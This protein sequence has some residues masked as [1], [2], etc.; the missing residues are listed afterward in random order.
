MVLTFVLI[1]VWM[2]WFGYWIVSGRVANQPTTSTD[3][4]FAYL[5]P[6]LICD[7]LLI[8]PV[9]PVYSMPITGLVLT[10]AGLV[11]ASWARYRL[12]KNWSGH[13]TIQ[14]DHQLIT[15][16]PYRWCR[17]PI[18]LGVLAGFVGT[19]LYIGAATSLAA[20]LFAIYAFGLKSGA[21]ERQLSE[22]FAQYTAY[23]RRTFGVFPRIGST[24]LTEA[25]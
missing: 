17:H 16:G 9:Y 13:L 5:V 18:Y 3:S 2:A 14:A 6:L 22:R 12:G 10:I 4:P 25:H 23:R 11:F 15:D 21:E 20:P 7:L 8:V 19:A 24:R 1:A